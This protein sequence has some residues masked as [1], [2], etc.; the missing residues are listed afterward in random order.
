MTLSAASV[1]CMGLAAR[2][3]AAPAAATPAAPK[4]RTALF[5]MYC[6]WT[7]EATLGRVPGV[8]AVQNI[9]LAQEP[10][11]AAPQVP[12]SGL[13]LPRVVGISV[14]VGDPIS[15]NDLRGTAGAAGQGQGQ[16]PGGTPGL[17]TFVP[18]PVTPQGC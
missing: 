18:V 13:E 8:V 4:T 1:L 6:Y 12:M 7:G 16:G 10:L 3:E 11:D 9:L 15:L 17:P 5:N 14:V 2:T